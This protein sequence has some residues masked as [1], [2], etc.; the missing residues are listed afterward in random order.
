M[1]N[2]QCTVTGSGSSASGSGNT[3]TLMLNLS[4]NTAFGGNKI[5]YT[6]ARDLQG[7]NSGWQALG[8]WQAPFTP[9]GTIAAVSLTPAR[10][11]APSGTAQ[12]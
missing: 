9:S 8:T 4:F 11:A 1:S 5:V 6:A 10:G 7:G 3:L 12:T 2:S